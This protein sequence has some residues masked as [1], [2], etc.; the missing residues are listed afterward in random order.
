VAPEFLAKPYPA[1]TDVGFT[2]LFEPDAV[3]EISCVAIIRTGELSD[4]DGPAEPER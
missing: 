4:R 1:W 2:E 3:V